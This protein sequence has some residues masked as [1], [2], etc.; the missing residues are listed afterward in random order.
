[1]KLGLNPSVVSARAENGDFAVKPDSPALKLGFNNL[2]DY[3]I[4]CE[5]NKQDGY[6][7][8]LILSTIPHK[9]K[10]C[11]KSFIDCSRFK[12]KEKDKA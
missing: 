9:E 1:M 8:S 6:L 10:E 11:I 5:P 2:A 7:E 12:D 4:V 3:H